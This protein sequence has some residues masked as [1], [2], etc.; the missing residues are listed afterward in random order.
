MFD[1]FRIAYTKH[2]HHRLPVINCENFHS[3]LAR[4]RSRAGERM[5]AHF[6]HWRVTCE[7]TQSERVGPISWNRMCATLRMRVFWRKFNLRNRIPNI[8]NVP[9][10]RYGPLDQFILF[11]KMRFFSAYVKRAIE[12]FEYLRHTTQNYPTVVLQLWP[13]QTDSF[14]RNMP[15]PEIFSRSHGA[16]KQK[17]KT[18]YI[19]T[20]VSGRVERRSVCSANV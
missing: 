19:Y 11:E 20:L 15:K 3:E 16:K 17:K 13:R 7:H 9:N 1:A 10:I 4:L 5:R 14:R 12:L 8:R 6:S 18:K 2:C